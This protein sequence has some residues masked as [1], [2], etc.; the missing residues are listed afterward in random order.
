MR[1]REDKMMEAGQDDATMTK[2]LSHPLGI[3]IEVSVRYGPPSR[4]YRISSVLLILDVSHV[5]DPSWIPDFHHGK[6]IN[7][8]C[9]QPSSLW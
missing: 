6:I 3:A 7:L 2:K 5:Y 9:F 8:P 1:V 4:V